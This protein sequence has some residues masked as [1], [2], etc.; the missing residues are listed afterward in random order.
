M[1]VNNVTTVTLIL[2]VLLTLYRVFCYLCDSLLPSI[3]Q[4]VMWM[5]FLQSVLPTSSQKLIKAGCHHS[6]DDDRN[7]DTSVSGTG[8]VASRQYSY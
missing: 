5:D 7:S 2:I 6:I 4:V 3:D 8:T 1:V